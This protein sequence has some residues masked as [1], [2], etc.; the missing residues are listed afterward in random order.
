MKIN[1]HDLISRGLDWDDPIPTDL[2]ALW[3]KIFGTIQELRQVT[4]ARA[5]VPPN[6]RDLKICTLDTADA[7]NQLVCVA[8]Y[9]RFSLTDGGYSCQLVFARTKIVPK[10]MSIP[11]AELLAATLN[12]T[13]GH[14][15]KTSFGDYFEK[16][17]KL[18]DSQIA[19]FWINSTRSELKLWAR[20]RV[21]EINRLTDINSWRY[22][23]STDMIADL[24]TRKGALIEDINPTGDWLNGK[25]WMRLPENEFPVYTVSEIILCGKDRLE[26]NNE[27]NKPN[28]TEQLCSINSWCYAHYGGFP[29]AVV[30]DQVKTRYESSQYV[31]DPNR[32]RLRKVVRILSLVYLFI[33]KCCSHCGLVGKLKAYPKVPLNFVPSIF[34]CEGD[35]YI[36]TEGTQ[37]DRSKLK[38]PA[39]LVVRVNN[40][41]TKLALAYLFRKATEEVKKFVGK[42][43]YQN[44]STEIDDILFY[45][46]RFLPSMEGGDGSQ[47]SD[48]MLDLSKTTFCVPITDKH[49]PIAYSIVNEVHSHHP[50]V[51]H[52]GVETTLRYVQLVA[53]VLGGRELVKKYG[54]KCTRCRILNKNTVKVIMGPLHEGQFKVAPAFYRTQVDLFGPFDAFD[55][56][57]KRKTV[58]IWF[59]VFCCI[60]TSAVD[61]RVM[62]DYSTEAFLMAFVRFSC[63]VG[64]PKLLL[65]DEGS[66]L[67]K[68]CKSM[69]LQ[70]TDIKSQLFTKYGVGFEVCPVGAH[71]MHGKVERKIQQIKKSITINME[72]N[73][74]SVLQWES[75][76][77]QV[78]N[79]INNLPLGLGSKV[80]CLEDLDLITPN[81]LLLGR[82]N[83]RCPSGPLT[84]Q[85]SFKRILKTN[86][87]IYNTWFRSWLKSYVPT[88]LTRPKWLTS[89]EDIKVGDVVLFLKSEKEF[90][91]DYQY[92]IIHLV[93]TGRDGHVRTVEV[94]YQN[95]NEGVKRYTSRGV[96]DLVVIQ[97]LDEPGINAELAE[98]AID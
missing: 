22:V 54:K 50:D 93:N 31:L 51:K 4:F 13:T 24:G 41:D 37:D 61:I 60:T 5:V 17:L 30:P 19:L 44:I 18:T 92:G 88:L 91:R 62:E 73:R 85:E 16:A 23:K 98:M 84:A 67:V 29:V 43:V 64:F 57:N 10:D 87:E 59:V 94:E 65:P 45:T 74:L 70:F 76:V 71:Y 86:G 47:L 53:Y 77:A 20:N 83:N 28:I 68:G 35:Q 11:R 82:N 58:K 63:R 48:V 38:C 25:P 97:P 52:S 3:I 89:D 55:L 39:G 21:I 7:S 1:L 80:E 96:R 34:S 66:Q 40:D 12:A 78:A 8:I 95:H 9:A 27:C 36:V 2:K 42:S 26:A 69:I 49:S 46:G 15:V 14:V 6:A 32:F 79:G 90:E 81:R 75:L 72:N 56:T 33:Q